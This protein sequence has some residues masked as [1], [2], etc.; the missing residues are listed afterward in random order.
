MLLKISQVVSFID[1]RKSRWGNAIIFQVNK[2]V[3]H[4]RKIDQIFG[5]AD[6]HN[7][8]QS[9]WILRVLPNEAFHQAPQFI[10]REAAE[11]QF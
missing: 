1:L 7:R 6:Q 4:R 3:F 5:M 9:L 8:L 2:K 11:I 10:K